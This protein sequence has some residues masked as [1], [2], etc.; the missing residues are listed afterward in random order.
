[1]TR[2]AFSCWG[3]VELGD[4][5]YGGLDVEVQIAL[6]NPFLWQQRPVKPV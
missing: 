3:G 1:M 2:K 4:R 6:E 5:R